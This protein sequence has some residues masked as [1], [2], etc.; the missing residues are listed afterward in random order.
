M[1]YYNYEFYSENVNFETAVK[2]CRRRSKGS[3][4]LSIESHDEKRSIDAYVNGYQEKMF[5]TRKDRFVWTGG[6]FDLESEQPYELRWVDQR[7]STGYEPVYRSFCQEVNNTRMAI[8]T[9]LTK[10]KLRVEKTTKTE[11]ITN[12][13]PRDRRWMYVISDYNGGRIS[14]SCWHIIEDNIVGE[15][16][17]PF[18]CKQ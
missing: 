5:K 3:R 7:T 1:G 9:T 14:Q 18:V 10:I 6:Y 13:N 16:K 12:L 15:W 11:N 4:L 17:L 8:D 2:F